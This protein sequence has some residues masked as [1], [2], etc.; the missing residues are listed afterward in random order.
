M[1]RGGG[2]KHF[3]SCVHYLGYRRLHQVVMCASQP[4]E[5]SYSGCVLVFPWWI[6]SWWLAGLAVLER[7]KLQLG[8][9]TLQMS[10]I[11]V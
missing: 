3:G 2:G 1:L 9:T 11:S 6:G 5:S 8:W 4:L 10:C 7:V